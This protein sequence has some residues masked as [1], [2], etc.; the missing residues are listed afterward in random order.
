MQSSD[1]LPK[2]AVLSPGK[3]GSDPWVSHTREAELPWAQVSAPYPLLSARPYPH[4][5]GLS[6]GTVIPT[7]RNDEGST[8]P[9]IGSVQ[10]PFPSCSHIAVSPWRAG[11]II[12]PCFLSV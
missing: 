7:V 6:V 5:P 12:Y 11:S 4:I 9:V 3:E 8:G 10:Y 2:V 1:F